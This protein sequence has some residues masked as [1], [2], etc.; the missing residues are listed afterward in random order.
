MVAAIK[1]TIGAAARKPSSGGSRAMDTSAEP[2]PVRHWVSPAAA[3]TR[4][5]IHAYPI[6]RSKPD[7]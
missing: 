4:V 2:N 5:T 1:A 3:A 6:M 7:S